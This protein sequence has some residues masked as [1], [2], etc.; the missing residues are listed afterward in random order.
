[1]SSIKIVNDLSEAPEVVRLYVESSDILLETRKGSWNL[2]SIAEKEGKLFL[3]LCSGISDPLISTDAEGRIQI[4][5]S[6]TEP[7]INER[8]EKFREW[9]DKDKVRLASNYSMSEWKVAD[10]IFKEFSRLFP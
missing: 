9:L 5:G 2:A 7:D 3:V 1:M 8:I 6:E 10:D 4:V